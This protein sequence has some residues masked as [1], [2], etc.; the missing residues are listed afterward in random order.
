MKTVKVYDTITK[1]MINVEVSE[2]VYVNFNRTKWKIEDNNAS[3]YKHEIQFSQ[4]F[5]NIDRQ[6]V[7]EEDIEEAAI[8]ELLIEKLVN[9][10]KTLPEKEL[11]LIKL[12]FYDCRSESECASIMRT[13]QQNIS[14]KKS[15]VLCKL[16]E[17]LKK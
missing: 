1:K 4:V 9:A 13:T 11:T 17:L 2:E 16:N 6:T 5:D 14:K 10:L 8:T 7:L 12:L 3:F 15:R